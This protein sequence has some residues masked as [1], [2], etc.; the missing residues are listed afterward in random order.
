MRRAIFLFLCYIFIATV[1]LFAQ[2]LQET[3]YLKNGSVIRGTVIEQ[4]PGESMKIKTRDGSIFVYKVTEIE[5]ITKETRSYDI[6][7]YRA[8]IDTELT[9]DW[10]SVTTSHGYQFNPYIYAG[11]GAGICY[12]GNEDEIA[13]PIFANGRFSFINGPVSPFVDL[14][15]GYSISTI[16]GLDGG[17]YMSPMAGVKFMLG[18]SFALNFATGYSLQRLGY[19]WDDGHGNYYNSYDLGGLTLRVGIE[20]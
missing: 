11:L 16:E 4:I 3:I 2:K 19:Y 12:W 8:F 1:S 6:L 7:G 10:L 20:F 15:I 14:R 17:F 18:R 5:K 9:A 13:I